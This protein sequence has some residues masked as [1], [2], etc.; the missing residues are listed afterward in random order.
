MK[1]FRLPDDFRAITLPVKLSGSTGQK[2]VTAIL[3]TGASFTLFSPEALV[4]IGC[5]P[6][7][8]KGSIKI[9]TAS[10]IEF[11]PLVKVPMVEFYGQQLRDVNVVSHSMPPGVLAEGLIGLNVLRQFNVYLEFLKKLISVSR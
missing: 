11:V 4:A 3:D 2:I 6:N 5:E 1:S 9:V 7:P 8:S 10:S